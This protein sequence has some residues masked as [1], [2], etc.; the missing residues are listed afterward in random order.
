ML[1]EAEP[2]YS[3]PV[4]VAESS[5]KY[6]HGVLR[7]S[8]L[9]RGVVVVGSPAA[10]SVADLLPQETY[11]VPAPARRP[12]NVSPPLTVRAKG[13]LPTAIDLANAWPPAAEH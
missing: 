12:A 1:P 4:F 11:T 10:N 8:V 9:N 7:I 2:M 5:A 6:V 3:P 13:Q